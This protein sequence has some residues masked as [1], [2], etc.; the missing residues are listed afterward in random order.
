MR[1]L[2][3]PTNP[4]S[5]FFGHITMI[6][7]YKVC[8]HIVPYEVCIYNLKNYRGKCLGWSEHQQK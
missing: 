5:R 3:H 8:L 1:S 4:R 6:L 7:K 2:F